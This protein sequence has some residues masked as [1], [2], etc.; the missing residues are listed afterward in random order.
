MANYK[1][2]P[3]TM[4]ETHVV[5]EEF[6]LTGDYWYFYDKTGEAIYVAAAK[7]VNVIERA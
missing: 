3:G 6:S 5:A 1:I 7:A 4:N 2:N